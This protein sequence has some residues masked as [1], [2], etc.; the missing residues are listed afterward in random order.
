[1]TNRLPLAALVLVLLA[2]VGCEGLRVTRPASGAWQQAGGGPERTRAA[3]PLAPP[4]TRAWE[5]NAQAAFGADAVAGGGGTVVVATRK[6][7][8][9]AFEAATGD[10]IGY[11]EL[12]ESVEGA[13]ALD[14]STLYAA[15]SG[16]RGRV[17]AYDLRGGQRLWRTDVGPVLSGVALAGGRVVVA[18]SDGTVHALDAGDGEPVWTHAPGAPALVQAAPVAT[19]QAVFAAAS[20]G[21]LRALSLADGA[22]LWSADL[23][24]PLRTPAVYQGT[25]YAA[26][27]RGALF[28]LDA[29][30]G[31]ER[32]R[33]RVDPVVTTAVRS[34]PVKLTAPAVA[35]DRVL[36]G[37]SDGRLRAYDA[38]TLAPLWTHAFED[39]VSAAPVLAGPLAFA[40]TLGGQVAALP[41]GGGAPVWSD[42][43]RSRV[44][45]ALAVVDGRLIV[46]TEPRHV[47][48]FAPN[49]DPL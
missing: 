44:K 24:A 45:S 20:D 26:T 23:G 2:A 31:A 8:V 22:L 13:P 35:Q 29:E 47:V 17:V 33:T 36:V 38:A 48:A 15:T 27:E 7:E 5:Q 16:R 40:A 30:T 10:R 43:V 32:A 12:G 41:V 42:S 11:V 28:A 49:A 1:M 19:A 39:G 34:V 37:G 6:G 9:Y 25:L 3:E 18:T 46:L 14:G 21:H 4:L